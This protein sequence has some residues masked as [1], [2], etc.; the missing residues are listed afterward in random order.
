MTPI[1]SYN[2]NSMSENTGLSGMI[3]SL[4]KGHEGC[5]KSLW[6]QI[7]VGCVIVGVGLGVYFGINRNH[8]PVINSA[9]LSSQQ[10]YILEDGSSKGVHT[11]VF[12]E[13]GTGDRRD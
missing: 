3:K 1:Q 10:A 7:V 6:K 2:P 13:E 5:L 4:Y 9:N 8:A 11:H 12:R